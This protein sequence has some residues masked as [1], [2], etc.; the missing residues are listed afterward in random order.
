MPSALG[1]EVHPDTWL[2]VVALL[3]GYA[4][5][6]SAW[7]PRY[8]PGRRPASRG[9]RT[10]F[11]AGVALLWIGADW[12]VH[13]LAESYLYSVH[14]VQHMTF[15]LAAA[16]LLI[17]GTP[18][19]LLRRLLSP[20]PVRAVWQVVT[21][22]LAAL[23]IVSAFT[24]LLHIPPMVNAAATNG[25]IHFGLHVLLVVFS[26]VMWWPVLSPLPELPHSC[27]PVRIVYLFGHSILPTV[28]ASF[29]TFAR[30]PLYTAYAEAPRLLPWLTAAQ[31]QQIAGLFM[32]II[33]GFVLWGVIAVLFFRWQ[34]EEASG[35]PDML[36]WRDLEGDLERAEAPT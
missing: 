23:L 29:L 6:L 30:E 13:T 10:C 18:G 25:L 17:L 32:K 1:F 33:G 21:R 11:V 26:V 16:P 34:A 7:G 31:D 22:P 9:Q 24:A 3:G 14:M 5:A 27:Y 19:W 36:Y 28:P 8:A 2:L 20:R 4:Y 12:P 15:Q 35:G